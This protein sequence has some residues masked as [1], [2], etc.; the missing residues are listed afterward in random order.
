MYSEIKKR[1]KILEYSLPAIWRTHVKLLMW[2]CVGKKQIEIV[3]FCKKLEGVEAEN[4]GLEV[5]GTYSEDTKP[6]Y[7]YVQGNTQKAKKIVKTNAQ[8]PSIKKI[9]RKRSTSITYG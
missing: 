4:N 3:D 9:L 5:M 6:K 8:A 1:K 7:V 2:D